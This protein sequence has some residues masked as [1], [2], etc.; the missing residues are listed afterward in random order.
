MPKEEKTKL[1]LEIAHVLFIDIVGYSKLLIDE[2]SESQH[3]LNRIVRD[4]ESVREAEAAEKLVRLPTGDGM[5]LVFTNSVEAPVE[6]ALQISEALRVQ[7]SLPVR[8]GIHSGPVHHLTDV[9]ERANIAG[10]GINISQRVMNCGDAGH[11]LISKRVADDLAQYRHW[12]PYLHDLGDCETK[13]GAVVSVVNLYA[14]GVGNPAL[15]QTFQRVNSPKITPRQ[16]PTQ[17]RRH[18]LAFG[19]IALIIGGIAFSFLHVKSVPPPTPVAS[20]ASTPEKS[21]AVLPFENLSRDPDNAYFAEGIQDEILTRLAK[22][23]DLKVISRTS[24]QRFK[25]SPDDLP[26]IAKQLGVMNILEGSVQRSADQVR[27]NVQLIHAT[28]D[29]HLWADSFD[30]KMTDIFAVE[31]EIAKTIADTLQAKLTGS[32]Q[33]AITARPTENTEAHQLYLKGR[34]FWNKRTMKDFKTAIGYFEQAVKADPHYAVAYAG[35]ADCYVLMPLFGGGA[36]VEVFPKA[37][38]MAT[39]ALAIDPNLAEA[40]ATLG[41]LHAVSDF[42]FAASGHEFER[43]IQLNPNY[44]TAHHWYGNALLPCLG[45]FDRAIAEMRRALELDP[46]SVIINGDL[47]WNLWMARR[48]REAITQL[49]KTIEM[50]SRVY[51]L[52]WYLGQALQSDGDL[53]GALAEY[54]QAAKLDDDP[55]PLG[56]LAAA[57]AKAG[58]RPAALTILQHLEETAKRRYVPDY[59]FAIVHLALGEKDKA[60]HWLE[61]SYE[62]RQPDINV[63]HFD[64]ALQSLHG[65]PRFEALAEKIVPARELAPIAAMP[66]R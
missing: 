61:S 58:E 44:T 34:F 48:N 19:A 41:L 39:K 6:C 40:H 37:K 20:P 24:T 60:M 2:Q 15:P 63:I 62:N 50:D 53:S 47:G 28:T 10:A 11:I 38:A 1:K 59:T 26:Q 66:S 21:I 42:D 43:A 54:E 29:A 22:V 8:M 18:W 56:L 16:S 3:E 12:Q 49:R 9:N 17:R 25:S 30:R 32:E 27:V 55:G 45:Q 4:T 57:K 23:A 36:P 14:D 33:H 64:P 52:H 7:Q 65:D 13:H 5:A 46:L 31:S 51:Y 35:M